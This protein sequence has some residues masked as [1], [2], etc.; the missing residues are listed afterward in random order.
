MIKKRKAK[1]TTGSENKKENLTTQTTNSYFINSGRFIRQPSFEGQ[2]NKPLNTNE[3]YSQLKIG[4]Y[5]VY[6]SYLFTE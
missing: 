1:N 4:N 2:G 3:Y 6:L 5:P